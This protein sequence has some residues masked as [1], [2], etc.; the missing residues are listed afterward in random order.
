MAKRYGLDPISVGLQQLFQGLSSIGKPPLNPLDLLNLYEKQLSNQRKSDEHE[1]KLQKFQREE[2]S[3]SAEELIS[4]RS[5]LTPDQKDIYDSLDTRQKKNDYIKTLNK[6]RSPIGKLIFG[7]P[8]NILSPREGS[9]TLTQQQIQDIIPALKEQG[10]SDEDIN[11]FIGQQTQQMQTGEEDQPFSPLRALGVGA[12]DALLGLGSN[13]LYNANPYTLAPTA[14]DFGAQ[15][16]NMLSQ[17]VGGPNKILPQVEDIQQ[18][19]GTALQ[20]PEQLQ[21]KMEQNTQGGVPEWMKAFANFS[22]GNPL[23]NLASGDIFSSPQTLGLLGKAVEKAPLTV[24]AASEALEKG[25]ESL[26]ADIKPRNYLERKIGSFS[27][28]LG[29]LSNPQKL[30]KEGMKGF[31]AAFLP[32]ASKAAKAHGL[33]YLAKAFTGSE[34]AD[35]IFT[36]AALLSSHFRPKHMKEYKDSL[37]A[38]AKGNLAAYDDKHIPF[39]DVEAEYNTLRDK[40]NL[41]NTGSGRKKYINGLLD[42]ITD[43]MRGAKGR[44]KDLFD[45]REEMNSKDIRG[46]AKKLGAE[47]ELKEAKSIVDK[48]IDLWRDRYNPE[49]VNSYREANSINQALKDTELMS[50]NARE[51]L[52]RPGGITGFLTKI[53]FNAFVNKVHSAELIMKYPG[54]RK[55]YLDAWNNIS[56]NNRPAFM[57][58]L[59]KM[60]EALKKEAPELYKEL[61]S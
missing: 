22:Q 31:A 33:G 30:A 2:R 6:E 28:L 19:A 57:V 3:R 4:A 48:A 46:Q 55:Y 37:Y 39:K 54:V 40:L 16:T 25:A 35:H 14:Y 24:G 45:L 61:S 51:W 15:L 13:L 17:G 58:N 53:G 36:N 44:I 38:K 12:K 50:S 21:Q 34:A 8:K 10:Y 5:H 18:A 27:G 11:S 7:A 29:A 23:A 20:A 59:K 9:A 49:I 60:S 41:G 42:S 56:K 52:R 1:R 26:G 47:G 43:S 32:A